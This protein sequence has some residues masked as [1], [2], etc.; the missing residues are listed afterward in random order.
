MVEAGTLCGNTDVE[1]YSGLNGNSTADAEAYTNI[2][3]LE[4]E[5]IISGL[6]R[7]DVVT[8][9]SSFNAVSKELLREATAAY[10]AIGVIAYDMSGYTS[11]IEGENMINILW[12]KWRTIRKIMLDQ[13]W[14]TFA[15]T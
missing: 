10:A 5:G 7:D 14:L 11:R 12:A 8:N 9:Y 13:K 4:A 6:V 2:Y 3:I 1:K 15:K